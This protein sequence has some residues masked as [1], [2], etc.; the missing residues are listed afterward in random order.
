M[1]VSETLLFGLEGKTTFLITEKLYAFAIILSQC[2][3]LS[4]V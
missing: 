4:S 1:E 2:I 3:I